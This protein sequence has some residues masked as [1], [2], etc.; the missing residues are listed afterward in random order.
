MLTKIHVKSP[1]SISGLKT[2]AD[3]TQNTSVLVQG[4]TKD[5]LIGPEI[6]FRKAL[7]LSKTRGD[8]VCHIMSCY[9]IYFTIS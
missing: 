9:G 6:M 5:V 8:E 4:H 2:V 7:T 3:T 1:I